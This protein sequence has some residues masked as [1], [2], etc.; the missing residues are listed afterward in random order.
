MFSSPNVGFIIVLK[1]SKYIYNYLVFWLSLLGSLLWNRKK[2]ISLFPIS[3]HKLQSF[4]CFPRLLKNYKLTLHILLFLLWNE[5]TYILILIF[6]LNIK[7]RSLPVVYITMKNKY[8][9]I[10]N[11]EN[12]LLL[13][14]TKLEPR[15]DQLY[16]EKQTRLF[17]NVFFKTL[18]LYSTTP[19]KKSTY[20]SLKC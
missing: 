20:R 8:R 11:V 4:F 13:Y 2:T 17:F 7:G 12:Q 5:V 14:Q 6:K 19:S 16:K 3:C 10:R 9:S 1:L 18:S 15:V